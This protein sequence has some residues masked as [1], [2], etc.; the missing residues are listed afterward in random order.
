MLAVVVSMLMLIRRAARPHVAFLGRVPGTRHYSDRE[1]NPDNETV[2]G[3]LM[4]RVEAALLYFNVEHVR[5][6]VW[7]AIRAAT[8]PPKLVVYDLSS[9]PNVDLAGARMLA[10][11]HAELQ[12]AGIRLRLVGAHAGVREMLSAEGLEE[13]V[14]YHGRRISVADVIDEFQGGAGTGTPE[15]PATPA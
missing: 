8:Q 4:F 12:G 10:A 13:R 11:L 1:R 3:A 9:T 14:G 6:A 5:D 2:V 7:Q 15:A